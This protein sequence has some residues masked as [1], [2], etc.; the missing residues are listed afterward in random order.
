[1]NCL[2]RLGLI[3]SS[4]LI[5]FEFENRVEPSGSEV[6]EVDLTDREG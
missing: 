4:D 6:E 3:L 1:M 5:H 2:Y